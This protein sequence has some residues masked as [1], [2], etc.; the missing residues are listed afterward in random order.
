MATNSVYKIAVIMCAVSSNNN[1][2]KFNFPI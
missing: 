1:N 2:N